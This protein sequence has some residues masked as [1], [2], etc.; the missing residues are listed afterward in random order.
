MI[1]VI[2]HIVKLI[3]NTN[4]TLVQRTLG[5]RQFRLKRTLVKINIKVWNTSKC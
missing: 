3:Q 1:V 5:I 4:D 2:I